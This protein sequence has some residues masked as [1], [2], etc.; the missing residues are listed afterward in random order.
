MAFFTPFYRTI[1]KIKIKTLD[2]VIQPSKN[3]FPNFFFKILPQHI[4]EDLKLE[5]KLSHCSAKINFSFLY[6]LKLIR[7]VYVQL[8]FSYSLFKIKN[9]K[10]RKVD[11]NCHQIKQINQKNLYLPKNNQKQTNKQ[12]NKI[13]QLIQNKQTNFN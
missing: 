9:K 2:K 7:D 13:N 4:F 1:S 3:L 11:Q 8:I 10:L 5:T 6:I 12:T